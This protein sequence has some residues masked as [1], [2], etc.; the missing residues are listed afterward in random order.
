MGIMSNDPK[1]LNNNC[2]F[3]RRLSI[4]ISENIQIGNSSTLNRCTAVTIRNIS[5]LLRREL[6][7]ACGRRAEVGVQRLAAPRALDQQHRAA[8]QL[9]HAHAEGELGPDLVV[10]ALRVPPR[11]E[12]CGQ[13]PLDLLVPVAV[14]GE[15]G[16]VHVVDDRRGP[17]LAR[18]FFWSER[19]H[20]QHAPEQRERPA[21]Q[22]AR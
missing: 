19:A 17:S 22:D 1:Y 14:A 20:P 18:G 2:T 16:D 6:V 3:H 4:R 12:P 13:L 21:L 11:A 7:G 15:V 10:G 9:A 5:E 8:V